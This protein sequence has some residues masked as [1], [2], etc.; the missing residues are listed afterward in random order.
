MSQEEISPFTNEVITQL[1]EQHLFTIKCQKC[2][3]EQYHIR[4]FN[5]INDTLRALKTHFKAVHEVSL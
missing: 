4:D 2:T 3:Y 1:E 5:S